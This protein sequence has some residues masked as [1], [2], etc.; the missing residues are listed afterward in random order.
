[1]LRNGKELHMGVTHFADVVAEFVRQFP[2]G[3]PT[4]PFFRDAHPRPGMHLVNGDWARDGRGGPRI[5]PFR[6]VPGIGSQ[7]PDTGGGAGPELG[8][9]G[10]RIGLGGCISFETRYYVILIAAPIVDTWDKELPDAGFRPKLHGGLSGSPVIKIADHGN[11]GCVRCP[12]GEMR[13]A[14]HQMGSEFLITA[15]VSSLGEEV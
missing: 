6:I 12:D 7:V 11:G 5:Q 8:V 10:V 14:F 15:V 13:P 9:K 1:M 4:V 2:P 3:E